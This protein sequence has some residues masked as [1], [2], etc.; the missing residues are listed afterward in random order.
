MT[1]VATPARRERV[2]LLVGLC[3]PSSSG[4]TFSALRLASGIQAEVGGKLFVIDTEARR[5]LHYADRFDFLH[6]EFKPPFG[7]LR[8]LEALHW[9]VKQ[10]ASVIVIDSMSHEHEGP[11]GY[12]ETQE[13]ELQRLAGDDWRKRNAMNFLAWK[14]PAA[15][16]R[17]LINGMLQLP[18]NFV[19]CF[20]AKEKLK[21]ERGKDP[22]DLG[23]MPIAGPEFVFEMTLQALLLPGSGGIPTWKPDMPGERAMV[24]LPAQFRSQFTDD[25]PLDEAT[26]RALAAWARGD[27]PSQSAARP[28][29]PPTGGGDEPAT[30]SPP[31]SDDL[32]EYAGAT[33]D[34]ARPMTLA[35]V[36]IGEMSD[37]AVQA[38]GK[39]LRAIFQL[40]TPAMREAWRQANEDDLIRIKARSPRLHAHVIEPLSA[41][42]SP[43]AEPADGGAASRDGD[44]QGG[45]AAPPQ[46]HVGGR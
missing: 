44:I 29:R 18:C 1:F 7:S 9:C 26:G 28:P 12:L 15:E 42:S 35:P 39:A 17:A 23:W 41:G 14:K 27:T 3:G 34:P 24:K 30:S 19:F 21:I 32:V 43:A 25:R 4:K 2:P 45:E 33:Y 13:A 10:G 46:Q 37:G 40:A 16:R 8:Y 38:L 5:S 6:V 31:P 20:R 36:P 22:V 11:G